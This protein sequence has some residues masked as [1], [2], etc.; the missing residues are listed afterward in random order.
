MARKKIPTSGRR[1]VSQRKPPA[2][3]PNTKSANKRRGKRRGDIGRKDA[4][5][6][7]DAE[8]ER[9]ARTAFEMRCEGRTMRA[10][11]SAL[12]VS[13]STVHDDIERVRTHLRSESLELAAQ[14]RELML[15]QLDE[16]IEQVMP[17]ILRSDLVIRTV[18]EGARG[19]V[20][21]T[22]EKYD[23]TMK[24]A[25]TLVRLQ[26]RKSRLIGC[27]APS[28]VETVDKT[29]FAVLP[30]DEEIQRGVS[31][32]AKWGVSFAPRDVRGSE[33]E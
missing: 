33:V 3:K 32:L 23:A 29:P 25:Q 17:Y 24:A 13:V 22:V 16:V 8:K 27:D 4:N 11:A 31:T 9:R 10:I 26:E 1:R 2:A 12:G 21:V 30:A 5:P 19:M 20:E 15:A 14:E 7:A 6:G 28:K 18:K